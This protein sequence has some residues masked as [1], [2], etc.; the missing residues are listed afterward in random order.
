V[1]LV[2]DGHATFA[3]EGATEEQIRDQVHR[4]ARYEVAAIVPAADVRL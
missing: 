1:T 3:A 4:V 2:A